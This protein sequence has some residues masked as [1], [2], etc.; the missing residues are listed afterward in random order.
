MKKGNEA[1]DL[2]KVQLFGGKNYPGR[3]LNEI[4]RAFKEKGN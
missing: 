1:G 2:L 4:T 3:I